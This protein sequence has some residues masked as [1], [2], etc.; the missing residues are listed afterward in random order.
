LD[1]VVLN[2]KKSAGTNQWN[3]DTPVE[4]PS[5]TATTESRRSR[6]SSFAPKRKL[7]AAN[8]DVPDSAVRASPETEEAVSAEEESEGEKRPA[9]KSRKLSTDSEKS[10]SS[11]CS[12]ASRCHRYKPFFLRRRRRGKIS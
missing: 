10:A 9:R 4:K 12:S 3:V 2:L 1:K 5:P 7:P 11:K 6:K 8:L